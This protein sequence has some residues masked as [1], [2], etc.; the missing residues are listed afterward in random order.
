MM[1]TFSLNEVAS[2][3]KIGPTDIT[4]SATSKA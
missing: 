1:S 3:R 2:I 4:V